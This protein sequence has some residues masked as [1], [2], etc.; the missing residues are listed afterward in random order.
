MHNY[1]YCDKI[2]ELKFRLY[3]KEKFS[4]S[5]NNLENIIELLLKES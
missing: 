2:F 5:M 4:K 1:Y 3:I